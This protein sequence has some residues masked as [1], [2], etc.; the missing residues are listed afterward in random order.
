MLP[1]S[2]AGDEDEGD[3]EEVPYDKLFAHVADVESRED[4]EQAVEKQPGD[5]EDRK[6]ER[7]SSKKSGASGSIS[8]KST[9]SNSS[10]DSST[11]T[12]SSSTTSDED[13][14][15]EEKKNEK[16]EAIE[17][18]E[19][20]DDEAAAKKKRKSAL[21]EGRVMTRSF[22]YGCCRITPKVDKV[23]GYAILLSNDVQASGSWWQLHSQ[24]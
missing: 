19:A 20:K 4:L 11:S 15:L 3:G 9:S 12:S 18:L 7:A 16:E 1:P 21:I 24:H 14:K 23:S 22:A 6:S 8:S 5:V 2:V 17:E 13:I 10:S